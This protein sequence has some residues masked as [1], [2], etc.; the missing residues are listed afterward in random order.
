VR[1]PPWLAIGN[2]REDATPT[3]RPEA[4]AMIASF[5]PVF[6][7]AVGVDA[8][9]RSEVRPQAS[10]DCTP[11]PRGPSAAGRW[12]EPCRYREELIRCKPLDNFEVKIIFDSREF[13]KLKA[14]LE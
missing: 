8:S 9:P 10:A 6:G 4:I 3:S 5:Q 11:T 1:W 7:T 2:A 14:D 12:G 13:R